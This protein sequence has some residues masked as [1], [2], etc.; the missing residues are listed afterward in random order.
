MWQYVLAGLTILVGTGL[1]SSLGFGFG[2]L[3]AP[4][5]ALI[6]QRLVPST[7]LVLAVVATAVVAFRERGAVDMRGLGWAFVGRLPG[8]AC[9]AAA[10]ALLS[11][12]FLDATFGVLVLAAV[13][14]SVLGRVPRLGPV[15]LVVA[16]GLSGLMGTSIGIG[17]PPMALLYQQAGA[18]SLRG[19]LSGFLCI[20][21]IISLLFLTAFGEVGAIDLA[22]AGILVLPMA[23]GFLVARLVFFRVD[24]QRTRSLVLLVACAAAIGLIIRAAAS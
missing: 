20:S 9:G 13:V 8:S 6:D 23:L 10:V 14:M 18:P 3:S 19:T 5:L 21:S 15:S 16:G 24:I 17:S 2:L 22:R 1:Q 11:V 12:R 7:F 4:L